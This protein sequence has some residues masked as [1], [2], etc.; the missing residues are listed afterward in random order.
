[1]RVTFRVDVSQEIENFLMSSVVGR[2]VLSAIL[3]IIYIVSDSMP[4]IS[5]VYVC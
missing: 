3:N 4:M 2:N 1:M 5:K